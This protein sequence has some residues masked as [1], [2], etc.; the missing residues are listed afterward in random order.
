MEAP[1][2]GLLEFISSCQKSKLI[3]CESRNALK[4]PSTF[5]NLIYELDYHVTK[6]LL[7]HIRILNSY[8]NENIQLLGDVNLQDY[9][10]TKSRS[11]HLST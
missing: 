1:G 3:A 10:L 8:E 11:V 6:Q 9:G 2:N 4:I 5:Y 7:S